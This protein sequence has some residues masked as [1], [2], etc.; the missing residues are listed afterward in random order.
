M[1]SAGCGPS[2]TGLWWMNIWN[3]T[4]TPLSKLQNMIVSLTRD[5]WRNIIWFI[6]RLQQSLVSESSST[7]ELKLVFSGGE[8]LFAVISA[9]FSYKAQN[10]PSLQLLTQQKHQSMQSL[11]PTLVHCRHRVKLLRNKKKIHAAES[12]TLALKALK[13]P[14]GW[15][16]AISET[17]PD[18]LL[19]LT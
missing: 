9:F 14:I 2:L 5:C 4:T 7:L 1:A 11:A 19:L 8:N 10:A 13:Q 17:D 18:V 6:K 12:A 3:S 16:E 15:G